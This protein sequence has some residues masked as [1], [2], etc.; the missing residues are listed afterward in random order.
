LE[1]SMFLKAIC[2]GRYIGFS[3]LKFVARQ[4]RG[5]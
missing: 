3:G 5:A 1:L 4:V 2:S